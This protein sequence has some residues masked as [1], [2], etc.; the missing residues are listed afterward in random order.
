MLVH[1][2]LEALPQA[3]TSTAEATVTKLCSECWGLEQL[4]PMEVQILRVATCALADCFI[5]PHSL[6]RAVD[7]LFH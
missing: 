3:Q 5:I 7:Y 2:V 6:Y 1:R 4:H